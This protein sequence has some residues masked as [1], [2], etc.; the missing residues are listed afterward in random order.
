MNQSQSAD[1]P[2]NKNDLKPLYVRSIVNSLG[3]G[4]VNPFLGVY[5]VEQLNASASEMGWFN[6]ISNLAPNMMQVAWGKLSDKI[7]R[8]IPFIVIGG[9]ITAVLWIPLMFVTSA[10]QL[11]VVIAVQS[12][13]GSMATPT[14]TALIGDLAHLSKR[15]ITT[16][17]INR[18]AAVGSLLATL[19]AGYLMVMIKGTL[20]QALFI[21]LLIAVFC[22]VVSSLVM[23]LVHEKPNPNLNSLSGGSVFSIADVVKQV[24]SNTDFVRLCVSSAIFGFFMTL[25]WPLFSITTIRVLNASMLEVALM[26]VIN[27]AAI[28]ALQPWGG[29]LVDSVGRR[30]LIVVYRLSL[31]LVPVFYAL[32]SS[33]YH[34][35]TLNLILGILTAFGEVA[36]FA[37]LL[38][39]T[40][41]ELRG[42]FTAF[43]NLVNG[44]VFFAGSLVGGYLGNYLIGVFGL[45]LGLQL[46]YALSAIG[47]GAGA[48]T[49]IT[50]KEPYRYPSTLRKEL[51][52]MVGRLPWMPER[53]PTQP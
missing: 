27:G 19:A 13:L 28:I 48:L 12:L 32:A 40:R 6:S 2:S 42:T 21:P 44:L 18:S 39:I 4:A 38:D 8:R 20:Q 24:R 47:R 9:L 30:P 46:V 14:W 15:G 10:T 1:K 52:N 5:T 31:I 23:I 7:G 50:L 26:S 34:L 29:K 41:E 36:I 51:R 3:S 16:A 25:C 17:T 33:V 45:V 49:F 37:Y 53:G 35:Y 22:G 43:Y 11:I